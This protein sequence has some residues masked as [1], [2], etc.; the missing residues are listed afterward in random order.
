LTLQAAIAAMHA[1]RGGQHAVPGWGAA[2]T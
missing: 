1:H 2:L